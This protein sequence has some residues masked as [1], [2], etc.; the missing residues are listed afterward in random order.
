[1]SFENLDNLE[2]NKPE[3][4]IE[5]FQPMIEAALLKAVKVNE[6]NNG[7]ITIVNVSDM[8]EE[9]VDYLRKKNPESFTKDHKI[10]VNKIL[11][12]YSEGAGRL[13]AKMQTKAEKIVSESKVENLAKIPKLILDVDVDIS[14]P[15]LKQYLSNAGVQMLEDRVEII[16]MDH[17]DGEDFAE[18]IY[19]KVISAHVS[20]RDFKRRIEDG[21]KIP[22]TDMQRRVNS[23][24][25]F[26]TPGQKHRDEMVNDFERAKVFG[27]NASKI[28]DFLKKHDITL[29]PKI[30][31]RV[32]NTIKLL[33]G[34]G[35]YHLDI[36]ERNIMLTFDE[37]GEI[38]D[39]YII[40]FGNSVESDDPSVQ[41]GQKSDLALINVY[42]PLTIS[43]DE[44][45]A[46]TNKSFVRRLESYEKL[47]SGPKHNVAWKIIE[48]EIGKIMDN[49]N[50]TIDDLE[51][52]IDK[53]LPSIS[54]LDADLQFNLISIVLI[55]IAEKNI[56]LVNDYVSNLLQRKDKTILA[57]QN[58][59]RNKTL[60][61]LKSM[62]K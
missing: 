61:V 43:A 36:H 17:I 41:E 27:Q 60:P 24:L 23:A 22:F 51:M 56:D 14:S 47:L 25:D 9:M 32:E 1:M 37:N 3:N 19:K 59:I 42:R 45:Q 46:K 40:D 21:E 48:Q 30:F 5:D 18:Y 4:F 55:K 39:V 44:R 52:I 15:D 20:L 53:N 57:I 16:M 11:K 58:N 35:I 49:D 50:A 2:F 6:G 8:P 10:I 54:R 33:N 7:I 62:S 26:E 31:D 12:I 29:D 34:E 13:E 28:I 38:S